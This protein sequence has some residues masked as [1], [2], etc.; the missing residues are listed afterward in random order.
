MILA[1]LQWL[2]DILEDEQETPEEIVLLEDI[3]QVVTVDAV[4]RIGRE[5]GRRH[6]RLRCLRKGCGSDRDGDRGGRYKLCPYRFSVIVKISER[7][8]ESGSPVFSPILKATVGD[9]GVRMTST[10]SNAF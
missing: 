8:I 2:P 3:G 5:F 4:G 6:G 7:Y 1:L 10:C 9:V